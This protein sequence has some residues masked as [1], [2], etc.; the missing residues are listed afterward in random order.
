MPAGAPF[1]RALV[2]IP[3]QPAP[4]ARPTPVSP[5]KHL[6]PLL[7]LAA[8]AS[9]AAAQN[10]LF[11]D[12]FND[13]VIG[14][15]WVVEFDPLYFWDV[16]E[17]GDHFQFN[18]LA[19]PFGANME[20]FRV[21]HAF[22]PTAG[23]FSMDFALEWFDP[24]G[25]GI[26][27]GTDSVY[28]QLLDPN[29]NPVVSFMLDDQNTAGGGQFV[30]DG[31]TQATVPGLAAPGD[32]VV[33][34]SRSSTGLVSYSV[35]EQGSTTT[36]SVGVVTDTVE[37]V[38]LF[39]EHTTA[40]GP[41]GP[42]I[43]PCWIDYVRI[44]DGGATPQLSVSNL[45][46]GGVATLS[47]SNATPLGRVRHGYSLSGGG[48]V[49]TPFGDLLLSPP[50]TE[51]PQLTADANGDAALAAPVPAGTTGRT[52]WFHAIDMASSTFSNGLAEVIG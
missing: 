20:Q 19:A 45:V 11:A 30:I 2:W 50:Y 6:A 25:L 14:S 31:A 38:R 7:A 37:Y 35:T 17:A 42:F 3:P 47:V 52:V 44:G 16:Y 24:T 4:T 40:C 28:V 34:L 12:E 43:G 41:C 32:A 15:G 29:L 36:G 46:A 27:S 49:G 33:N 18:G 21:T 8:V 51:L 9:P 23:G 5:M 13:G 10:T 48:P 26:G 39:I 22:A 1:H